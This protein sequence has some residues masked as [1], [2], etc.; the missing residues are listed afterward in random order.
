MALTRPKNPG[1]SR[2]RAANTELILTAALEVF[3]AYGFRGSTVDQIA[4]RANMSKPNLLYYFRR[5]EDIY[6]ALLEKTLVY[7][8]APLQRLRPEGDPLVEIAAYVREKLKMSRDNPK[9]SRLFAN[10]LLHG[11]PAIGAFLS[12]P[13]KQLVDDKV[14]VIRAWISQG[15]L[16]SVDPHHLIFALW[17]AAETLRWLISKGRMDR[18]L[19]SSR[20]SW[21]LDKFATQE[22]NREVFDGASAL[23]VA[24]GHNFFDAI[25]VSA[26]LA[27]GASL[28]LSEDMQDGFKWRGVTIANP[29]AIEP[30]P[31]IRAMLS[32]S[33]P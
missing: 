29:F 2:I 14:Q 20:V 1:E 8:L 28:L 9:A 27:G 15:R 19:A 5:K 4:A 3:S 16:A 10:E 23:T 33:I 7:W 17:A 26:A 13:L 24:H 6:V 21:W 25:I 31:V 30:Q 12:G 32:S 18:A 22:T 11:A